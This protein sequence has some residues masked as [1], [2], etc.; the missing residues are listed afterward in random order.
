MNFP[1][2]IIESAISLFD[3]FLCFYFISRFNHASINPRKNIFVVPSVLI[4][5]A[6]SIVN[7]LFLKGFNILG[8]IIFLALYILYAILISKKRY[9]KAIFSACIFEIVFIILSSLL[10]LVISTM[11]K[12]YDQLVQGANSIFRY[13]YVLMHKIALF[14]ALKIILMLFKADNIVERKQGIIAFVFSFVTILGLGSTM[15]IVSESDMIN[16]QAQA[17]F[18]SLTFT[19]CN[20]T[21]YFLIYQ[22]QKHQQNKYELKLL[23]DKIAFEEIRHKDI[24]SIW[25]NV[26]KIQHD[27]K[28]HLTIIYGYLE[29]DN[30]NECKQ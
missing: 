7:D 29:G 21:I 8:T 11:I 26:N 30:V 25:S 18:I 19:F 4:I 1:N 10:Y 9:I 3:A 24:N 15:Y 20:I 13:I 14:V 28:H 12:D 6:F 2:F 5:Y 17:I 23:Q 22:M 27:I 16:I